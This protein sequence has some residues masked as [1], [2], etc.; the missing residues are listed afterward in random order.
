MQAKLPPGMTLEERNYR[1]FER[2]FNGDSIANVAEDFNLSRP[3][4]C[5]IYREKWKENCN[6]PSGEKIVENVGKDRL[7]KI[8]TDRYEGYYTD[9]TGHSIKK[10]FEGK[11]AREQWMAWR[12]QLA[13][14]KVVYV[15]RQ[16]QK[17]NA[18]IPAPQPIQEPADL[19][20]LRSSEV[21]GEQVLFKDLDKALYISE[22]MTRVTGVKTEVVEYN[23]PVFWQG[24][25]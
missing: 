18:P 19:Y 13:R 6:M 10:R 11:D 9:K 22:M 7:I 20:I 5:Q 24:E 12:E 23:E 14:P 4:V 25:A 1:I 8:G 3:R 21:T 17:T 16:E 2:I 15:P